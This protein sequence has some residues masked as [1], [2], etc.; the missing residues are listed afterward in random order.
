MHSRSRARL[1]WGLYVSAASASWLMARASAR[2]VRPSLVAWLMSAP[3]S[4]SSLMTYLYLTGTRCSIQG[5]TC[6]HPLLSIRLDRFR[7]GLQRAAQDLCTAICAVPHV[8]F[9]LTRLFL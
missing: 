1:H 9:H 5:S 6:M 2:G 7:S 8:C 4:S 3:A